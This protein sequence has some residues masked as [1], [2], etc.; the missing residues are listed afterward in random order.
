[1]QEA[2]PSNVIAGIAAFA[3]R[4]RSRTALVAAAGFLWLL[5]CGGAAADVV[6]DPVEWDF[7]TVGPDAVLVQA[8]IVR[9][10]D[11]EELEVSL[12]STCDCVSVEDTSFAVPAGG[13]GSTRIF[14]DPTH[15]SGVVD[16]YL[17]VRTNRKG[18][19]K[20]MFSIRGRV[21]NGRTSGEAGQQM[22]EDPTI[23]EGW[24]LP[25]DRVLTLTYY[26]SRGC[27]SCERFLAKTVPELESR[28][29]VRI[30]VEAKDILDPSA[31]RQYRGL[32]AQFGEEAR[33]LPVIVLGD[34]VLQGDRE[35]GDR[36]EG[37]IRLLQMAGT[38]GETSPPAEPSLVE[39]L[40]VFPVL[41][42][43]LLDG[44]NPCAF[45]TIIFLVTS[46]VFAGRKRRE[47][48]IVGIC[49]T[50][51]VF[52]T[53][54]LVGFGLFTAVRAASAF[55]TVSKAL[56]IVLVAALTILAGLSVY[57]YVLIRQGRATEMV[58]QLPSVLKKRMQAAIKTQTRRAALVASAVLLG[59]LV[60]LFEL[61]CTGQVYFP[62]I[63]FLVRVRR[64][65]SAYLLLGVY[66]LG[67][68]L[69]LVAVFVLIYL[70]VRSNRLTAVFQHNMGGIK[71]G[72]AAVFVGLA[73]LTFVT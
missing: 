60:S 49:F 6:F 33:A 7:G 42:A 73:I 21:L 71:I 37:E 9:N 64:D 45:T 53:Y 11:A 41:G 20:A 52:V 14:F 1:M 34:T 66:N 40:A 56:R 5:V 36:L 69:P 23:S 10:N 22:S 13:I 50:A 44:V 62:T 47:V 8:L 16:K 24:P 25:E 27:R 54:L 32:M 35:I 29:G 72:L 30:R 17:I 55:P 3:A 70:G 61:A 57:D 2:T 28:I 68:V 67:F 58:L 19:E 43:G 48:L 31:Y 51:S 46:L 18:L 12:L 15:E 26:Y 65:L 59:F 4:K 63:V 38:A 39:R